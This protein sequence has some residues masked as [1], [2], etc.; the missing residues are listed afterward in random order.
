MDSLFHLYRKA[1]DY[2]PFREAKEWEENIMKQAF[3]NAKYTFK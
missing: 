1:L 3:Q 2:L